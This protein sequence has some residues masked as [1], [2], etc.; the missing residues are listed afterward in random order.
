MLRHPQ[1]Q[2]GM[3]VGTVEDQDNL[4]ARTGPHCLSKRGQFCFKE[5]NRDRGSQVEDGTS[6][7]GLDKAH[8][9]AP[10]KAVLH[11]RDGTLAVETPDFV[12]DGLQSDAMF[13]DGP[14]LDLGLGEGGGDG[15][16]ERAEVFLKASCAWASACTWRGRGLR[17]LPSKRTR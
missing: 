3:P 1:P 15:L 12:Q 5:R 13:V 6:R 10:R 11:R 17:R 2:T 14:E 4:F 9:I 7:G 8:Q 16:D